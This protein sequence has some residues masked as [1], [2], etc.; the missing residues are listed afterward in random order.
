VKRTT[1]L[2]LAI[3]ALAPVALAQQPA[4]PAPQPKP[5]QPAAGQPA[6]GQPAAGQPAAGQP[7]AGQPAAGQPAA[8]DPAAGAPAEPPTNEAKPAPKKAA[9]VPTLTDPKYKAVFQPLSKFAA[10]QKVLEEAASVSLQMPEKT[11][12]EWLVEKN[13]KAT[14]DAVVEAVS[15]AESPAEGETRASRMRDLLMVVVKNEKEFA[16][17]G[18]VA[19]N[20]TRSTREGIPYVAPPAP[21]ITSD[22]G[23]YWT[24]PQA[25]DIAPEVD[26]MFYGILG[27]SVFCFLGISIATIYFTWKY[28]NRKGHKAEDSS[29]HNDAL[30][31]TWTVLPSILLVVMFILGWKGF[32]NMMTPPRHALEVQVIGQKWNW[33]FIYPNGWADEILHVPAGEPVR[34]VMRSED[35]LHDFSLPAFRVKQDVIPR[36]YTKLWFKVDQPGVYRAFCAEYCGQQHGDMKTWVQVHEAGGYE[37]YLEKA[38]EAIRGKEPIEIGKIYYAKRGCGQCHSVDGGART[39]PTFKGIWGVNRKFTDGTSAVVDENYIRESILEPQAK[40]REG[41]QPVMPTFKG[42]LKDWQ[43]DGLI[44]YIKS[45][46]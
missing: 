12:L 6:A 2:T 28:R 17:M 31:I 18:E 30:E 16:T 39:G 33:T 20:A 45:L 23:G 9:A 7:A 14:L 10:A 3:L 40:V 21:P 15:V 8:A 5:A 34:L 25:S 19:I 24:Q 36:R 32:V 27:L 35:V 42:K 43:I 11:Y 46:K 37:K 38:E 22:D 4:D 44:A 29:S 1:I 26:W 13:D 41:Y